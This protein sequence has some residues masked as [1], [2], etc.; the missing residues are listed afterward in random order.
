MWRSPQTTEEQRYANLMWG[1][2]M[3][4]NFVNLKPGVGYLNL[5]LHLLHGLYEI[6]ECW[7]TR[8]ARVLLDVLFPQ[9]K[10]HVW[11]VGGGG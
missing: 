9:F 8:Q 3:N 2:L 1:P 10:G 11:V 7:M 5:L 4:V 6:A